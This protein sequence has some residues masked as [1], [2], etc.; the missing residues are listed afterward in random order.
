M[1][2]TCKKKTAPQEPSFFVRL[3]GL[4]LGDGGDAFVAKRRKNLL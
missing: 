4:A 1:L 3:I 2:P